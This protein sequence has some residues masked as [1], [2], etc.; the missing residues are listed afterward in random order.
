[1]LQQLVIQNYALIQSLTIPFHDGFTVITGETGA[2][3]SIIIDAL[4]LALGDRSD[5]GILRD[6][7]KKCV[8]EAAFLLSDN[9][10]QEF[11]EVNELEFHIECVLRREINPQGKSRAFVNDT[12]VTLQLLKTIGM[13]LIDIHSQHDSLLLSDE[14]FQ[15]ELL[16]KQAQNNVLLHDYKQL[17]G[18]F[19][20]I[21][22]QLATLKEQARNNANEKDYLQFQHNE[23]E[24]ANLNEDEFDQLQ[25]RLEMLNHAEEIKCNLATSI[26]TLSDNELSAVNLLFSA[27]QNINRIRNFFA[28]G[29]EISERIES[30]KIELKD[31]VYELEKIESNAAFDPD[32][33]QR[34]KERFDF[35]QHLLHKHRLTDFDQLIAL[36]KSISD[37]IDSF[38]SIDDDIKKIEKERE[39]LTKTLHQK[40]DELH[41]NRQKAIVSFEKN[42]TEIIRQ[43]NM[44]NG[45]FKIVSTQTEKLTPTGNTNVL[46][47]FSANK[48]MQPEPIA[49]VASGGEISRLMLAIKQVA[50]SYSYI[51]SIIFDEIDTGVSGETAAK[52]GHILHTMSEK[53]Q[54]ISISHLPQI[55]AKAHH[56]LFVHKNEEHENT[57]SDIK[58]LTFDERIA[59]IAKMISNGKPSFEAIEA[60]KKLITQE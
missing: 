41:T 4:G 13:Q 16:D 6:K 32:E 44:P 10:L 58:E 57:Q 31:I 18:K 52:V 35:L 51:A 12:P 11:F 54:V 28:E 56:H 29:T 3:K 45:V 39:Q 60:A 27:S 33:M 23:L 20:A 14:N 53:I 15:L 36:R 8:V 37:K 43:L 47:L 5:S 38:C 9:K 48:G 59:E 24:K 7:E 42:V 30:L 17:F 26:A 40:A 34:L 50:S 1:M 22:K 49:K 25:Q 2:G 21:E 19:T 46:F 55:A